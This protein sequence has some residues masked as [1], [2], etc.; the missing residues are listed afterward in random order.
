MYMCQLSDVR[1]SPI[2][3]CICFLAIID[4]I[5]SVHKIS[6]LDKAEA[7]TELQLI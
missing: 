2:L 4:F 5:I 6:L 1:E 7:F 3:F